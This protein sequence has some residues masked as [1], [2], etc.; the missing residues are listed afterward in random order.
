MAHFTNDG[1]AQRHPPEV[2]GHLA[3]QPGECGGQDQ[4]GVGHGAI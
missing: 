3:Q 2:A 1:G 4:K